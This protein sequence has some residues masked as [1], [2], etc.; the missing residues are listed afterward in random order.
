MLLSSP[1]FGV[2]SLVAEQES[3]VIS[4]SLQKSGREDGC[5][6]WQSKAASREKAE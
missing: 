5:G 3:S 4:D 6:D 1:D 2:L